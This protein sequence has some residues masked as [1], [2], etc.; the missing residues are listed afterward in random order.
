MT[1]TK[2]N[3]IPFGQ[4]E[5]I[6]PQ[7]LKEIIV[8]KKV[9]RV[10]VGPYITFYF[11]NNKTIWWQIQEMLRIE[12]G[13]GSQIEEELAAYNPLIPFRFP[14][15][16]FRIVATMMIEIDDAIVRKQLLKE[17]KGI[18]RS[19]YLSIGLEKIYA[20]PIEPEVS[21]TTEEGKTSA[22]HFLEFIISPISFEQFQKKHAQVMLRVE[23]L[24][25]QEQAFLTE[26]LQASLLS[27]FS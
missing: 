20:Q 17:F 3:I 7:K 5:K 8:I 14:N 26:E 23:H 10:E 24:S 12:K 25:Y 6:R 15:G 21:R 9:R 1:I 13:G 4:F 27:D 16:F 11:E 22:V 19:I 2:K 18:E